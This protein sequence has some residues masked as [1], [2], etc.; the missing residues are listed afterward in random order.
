VHR[1]TNYVP[2]YKR[3]SS[4]VKDVLRILWRVVGALCHVSRFIIAFCVRFMHLPKL[5]N[6]LLIKFPNKEENTPII[7]LSFW[8]RNL[9]KMWRLQKWKTVVSNS[10]SDLALSSDGT[11][12][13]LNIREYC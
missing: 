13:I 4:G 1:L 5:E 11:V 10:A 3:H 9:Y 6:R 2:E 12:H 8:P 7:C